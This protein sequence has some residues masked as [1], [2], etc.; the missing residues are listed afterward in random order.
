MAILTVSDQASDMAIAWPA[1]KP[2][3]SRNW[4]ASWEGPLRPFDKPYKV[5]VTYWLGLT[6]GGCDLFNFGPEVRV[7]EPD[8]AVGVRHGI[9]GLP[10]TYHSD[11]PFP[12]LCLFDPAAEDWH[13]SILLSE[14]IVPWTAQWLGFLELWK[15]TGKWTGPERH[16][17]RRAVID[18]PRQTCTGP[19][20]RMPTSSQVNRV[21]SAEG[22]RGSRACLGAA[23][24]GRFPS[25]A[26]DWSRVMREA[27]LRTIAGTGDA[28][29]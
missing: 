16:P 1:L 20:C 11:G 4:G 3:Y 22:T 15:A 24:R 28:S 5:Q 9:I 21:E 12:L 10:H 7:L 29:A 8:I 17:E 14:T 6:L 13:P 2:I 25:L 18:P 26:L 19:R 23:S 27:P